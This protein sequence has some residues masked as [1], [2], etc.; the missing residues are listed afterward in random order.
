MNGYRLAPQA[1][2]DILA[3]YLEGHDRFGIRQAENYQTELTR[4]FERLAMFPGSGRLREE[5]APPIR[6]I[7]FGSHVVVYEESEEGVTILRVRH[8]LEDWFDNPAEV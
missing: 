5:V 2:H 4:L 8:S 6:V 3:A 7:P 1:T